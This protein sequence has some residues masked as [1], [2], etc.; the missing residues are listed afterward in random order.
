MTIAATRRQFVIPERIPT[1]AINPPEE[2]QVNQSQPQERRGIP[3]QRIQLRCQ[4]C[5]ATYAAPI[6]TYVDVGIQPELKMLLLTGQMNMAVCPNCGTGAMLAS[7]FAY[8]DPA[9]QFFFVYIPQELN[10]R[11]EDQE[12]FVGDASKVAL[13]TL[14]PDAPRGYLLTPKRFIS[15]QTLMETVLEGEGVTKE[16]MQAQR[17]RLDLLSQLAEA[18][19]ADHASGNLDAPDAKLP[20]VVSQNK[21]AL[22]AE[23]F[24]TLLSYI[25]AAQQQ[26]REDSATMLSELYQRTI[27]LSG[28]D[29]VAAGLEDPTVEAI[30]AALRDADEA[31]LEETISNY[32]QVLDDQVFTTWDEQI[33]AL[34]ETERTAAQQ[35]RE[36][37]ASTVERM[38]AEAQ[39]MF[40]GASSL[41]RDV[42]QSSDPRAVLS[43]RHAEINEAFFVVLDA[44]INA[45]A[46]AGQQNVAEQLVALRHV[47]NDVLQEAMTPQERLINQLLTAESNADATKLLRKNM[48][49]VNQDFIKEVNQLA[50]DMEKSG[51]KEFVDRLRQVSREAAS[52]LF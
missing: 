9:K 45:A 52:L 19:E 40:E 12:K 8:H 10:L 2:Q 13:Q 37:V 44:N 50:E 49:L 24:A 20:Q 39:A 6:W 1:M 26:G 34:P 47:T 25:Q 48:A 17:Q 27:D 46:R 38:D 3:A 5:Q 31:K 7:P 35:R 4:N 36:L 32:R 15:L 29:P 23:F 22:D 16:M 14:P 51:R 43:E 33:A 41:L 30:I 21:A 28:F 11:V 18:L 42:V